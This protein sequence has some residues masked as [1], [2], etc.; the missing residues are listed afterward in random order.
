VRCLGCTFQAVASEFPDQDHPAHQVAI[1]HKQRVLK[2]L[3]Q[4][5]CE[6]RLRRPEVLAQQ[7]LLLMDGAWVAAR[8]FGP[9]N[10]ASSA[11]EAARDLIFAHR[12]RGAGGR[13]DAG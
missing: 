9:G 11:E 10:H 8:M 2:R 1:G 3:E 4:L 13:S 12:T 5:A 6:A 7:L